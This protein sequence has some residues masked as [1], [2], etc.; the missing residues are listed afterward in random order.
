MDIFNNPAQLKLGLDVGTD[1]R[2]LN[3]NVK[4]HGKKG[5]GLEWE[6]DNLDP[7]PVVDV[8]DM[9]NRMQGTS[10]FPH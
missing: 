4:R 2:H 3:K 8:S 1:L 5:S 10:M 9:F 6:F 7:T